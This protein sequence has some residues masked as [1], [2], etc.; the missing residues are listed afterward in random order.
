[1]ADTIEVLQGEVLERQKAQESLKNEMIERVRIMEF[2]RDQEKLMILQSR[3][4][5]MGEMIGNIAHQWRHPLNILGLLLQQLEMF[6]NTG[7]FDTAFLNNSV[8]KGMGI[9]Q[10]MS[11]T[12]DDFRNYFRP[13]K[14]QKLF[15]IQE[16]ISSTIALINDSFVSHTIHIEVENEL[17]LEMVGFPNEFS[18]ALLNILLNAKDA[19]LERQIEG[20]RISIA[21]TKTNGKGFITI[22]DNAGGIEDGILERIFDPYFTTKGPQQ[23]TGLGLYMAK[24]II[25]KNMGGRL[26]ARND[27]DGAEFCIEVNHASI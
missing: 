26:S 5:A 21:V 1:L 24:M 19:L 13:E 3:Q 18:Q 7:K 14:E 15:N 9:I 11:Q 27:A 8:S 25:E 4:A 17:P 16:S 10:H 12:I 20:P 23:G 6:Y 2:M 22:R